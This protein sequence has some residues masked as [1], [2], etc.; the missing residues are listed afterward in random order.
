MV[1][2]GEPEAEDV[3][4]LQQS[5]DL[6]ARS[7]VVAQPHRAQPQHRD[8][9]GV[10]VGQ[11]VETED[12]VEFVDTRQVPAGVG[13]SGLGADLGRCAEGG[14]DL[15]FGDQVQEVGVPLAGVVLLLVLRQPFGLEEVD[16]RQ[17]LGPGVLIE[18]AGVIGRGIEQ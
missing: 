16:Q 5:R 9:P 10:P 15:L 13:R 11:R 7:F 3:S 4:V 17:Q 6:F 1:T 2:L 12:L 8:L 14:E 18:R